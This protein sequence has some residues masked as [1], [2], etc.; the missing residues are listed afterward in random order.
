MTII[1]LAKTY[2]EVA[3]GRG[4]MIPIN[5]HEELKNIANAVG[6]YNEAARFFRD[7]SSLTYEEP[8]KPNDEKL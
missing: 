6:G 7:V 8:D 2:E 1:E 5:Y 3:A 4:V